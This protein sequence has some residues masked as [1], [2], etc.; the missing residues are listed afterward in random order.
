MMLMSGMKSAIT[1]VPT[2]S[3]SITIM[4]G[5]RFRSCSGGRVGRIHVIAAGTAASTEES[6]AAMI[7]SRLL[8]QSADDA[9][10]RHEERDHDRAYDQREHHDHDR[11]EQGS[12]GRHRVIDF[13]IVNLGD[14]QQHLG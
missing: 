4:I 7:E 5:C 9:D 6:S 2:I 12:E 11:L 14:L 3:A 13:I 10:E 8:L 1:I